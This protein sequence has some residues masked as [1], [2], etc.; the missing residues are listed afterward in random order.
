MLVLM[1]AYEMDYHDSELGYYL[2]VQ[3]PPSSST[4]NFALTQER[5]CETLLIEG[6]P[7]KF[8]LLFPWF[9][10]LAID[11]LFVFHIRMKILT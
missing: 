10:L 2:L 4:H 11:F 5:D 7:F 6:T 1:T 9:F 8:L 3:P